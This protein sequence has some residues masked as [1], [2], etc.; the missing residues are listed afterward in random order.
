MTRDGKHLLVVL[1][2]GDQEE[3]SRG[4]MLLLY[5]LCDSGPSVTLVETPV[6]VRPTEQELVSI[7][8][9]PLEGDVMSAS[10]LGTLAAV[11]H[12]GLLTLVDI[13]TLEVKATASH[14]DGSKF[15]SVTYCNSKFSS[16]VVPSEI[17]IYSICAL[18][19]Y[20]LKMTQVLVT[21]EKIDVQFVLLPLNG[22]EH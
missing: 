21:G 6:C 10:P 3:P 1:K 22:T 13:A 11:T 8:L 18:R 19:I 17:Y 16:P 15:V 4:G 14:Q 2:S 9:L 20:C 7:T 12:G 5:E